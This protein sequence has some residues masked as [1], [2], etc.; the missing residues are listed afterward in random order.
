M[1]DGVL[2]ERTVDEVRVALDTARARI[3][4]VERAERW[5]VEIMA[6]T[7]GFAPGVVELAVDAGCTSIG[8]N[9]AQELATK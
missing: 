7:T 9:Y 1:S 8:E 5:P 6:V 3:D 2:P 4:A